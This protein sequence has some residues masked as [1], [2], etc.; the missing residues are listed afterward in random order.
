MSAI[1][2][3]LPNY[4]AYNIKGKKETWYISRGDGVV[5]KVEWID[6]ALTSELIGRTQT[7]PGVNVNH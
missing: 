3:K 1:K 6:P 5:P 2:S 4:V 7:L